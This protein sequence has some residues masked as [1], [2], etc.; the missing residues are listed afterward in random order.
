MPITFWALYAET[1]GNPSNNVIDIEAIAAIAHEAGIPLVIDNTFATP[2]LCRPIE[3]GADIVVHSATK[4][5]G[6]HGTSMGGVL[7]ESGKRFSRIKIIRVYLQY[8]EMYYEMLRKSGFDPI[9]ERWKELTNVLGQRVMVEV[10]GRKYFGE[11]IDVDNDG[12]LIIRDGDGMSQRIL[13][14]D[15]HLDGFVKS[16]EKRY[17]ESR[18]IGTK[19]S[20]SGETASPAAGRLA[21]TFLLANHNQTKLSRYV[22][23]LLQFLIN[24]ATFN[25]LKW[26][27]Q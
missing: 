23:E 15:L 4:F 9:I 20:H 7:I 1:I 25:V 17:C 24:R 26:V 18:F 22:A 27:N 14:G 21:M 19:Q 6:G 11:V 5:I 13:S 3:F 10:M 2:Y 12:A 16:P 8:Y